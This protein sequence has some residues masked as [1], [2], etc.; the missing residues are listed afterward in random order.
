MDLGDELLNVRVG[1]YGASFEV[2]ARDIDREWI[3]Q[4]L[5]AS[6]TATVRRRKLPAEYVVW[7]VIGMALLRD[8]SISEV[9]RHLN[10]VLP[11]THAPENR[12]TVT[13]GAVVQARDRLGAEPLKALFERTAE[14]WASASANENRWRGLAIY[15]VDG[16]TLR[17][18]D[19]KEN[20]DQFGRPVTS[21]GRAGYPQLR[22]VA[23]M[24]LRSHLIAG[25]VAGP[26]TESE[27]KLAEPLWER[28]PDF[29]LTV[30]DRGFISYH[31]FHSIQSQGN[32]RHWLTRAKGNLKLRRIQSLGHDDDLVECVSAAG[33]AT[34]TPNCL[35]PYW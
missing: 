13:G 19:T 21:R 31:L 2:F 35:R 11:D 5:R 23:L 33:G 6:G 14:H 20:E 29:S 10:L 1:E 32:Q 8:R 18:P 22:L 28:L 30:V 4:A 3:E 9:V 24:V 27:L 7:I 12:G 15:G 26:C 34:S 17:V 16:S 25:L